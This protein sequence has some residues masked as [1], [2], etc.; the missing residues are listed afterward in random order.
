M[1]L[2]RLWPIFLVATSHTV[3]AA[4]MTPLI[5]L[6]AVSRGASPTMV[7]IVAASA[8]VLPL[9]LA[10]WTGAGADVIGPRRMAVAG[11]LVFVGSTALIAGA[12]TLGMLVV[13]TAIAGLANNALFLASQT[14][15][16]RVSRPQ[17]R[18]RNFGFFTFWVSGGQLA[19][20]LAGGFLADALSIRTALFLCAAFA[21]IP[22]S[23]A[24]WLPGTRNPALATEAAPRGLRARDA[25]RAAWILSRRRDLRFV[26]LIAFVI[27]FSWS[28]KSSFYPLYLQS[29]GLSKS[30]IGLIF[31]FLGAGSM[32]VRPLVG[33]AA[34]RFG[35]KRVLLG[36][37]L[38]A[39]AAIAT[40]PL[41]NRFWPLA[42][43]AAVTG[44]AW[45]F[46]QPLTMSLAA[47]S[48]GPH[49]RGLALSLRMT[50]NRLAEVA[51]PILFGTLV[52]WA[53]LGSAFFLS[54]VALA[55]GVW[56]IARGAFDVSGAEV[57]VPRTGTGAPAPP[58]RSD[59]APP[60]RPSPA[61]PHR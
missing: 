41:L 24:L 60:A 48:V 53:G 31:S 58:Y 40:I 34:V 39:T 43:A 47:G 30:A 18:D 36:A 4:A 28:I 15:V 3:V 19:G 57:A 11:G 52:A 16:A 20:P 61:R 7:G 23:L 12:P 2:R 17:N 9:M 27:I 45:G 44:M 42:L 50:S 13:G 29:V 35:R 37:V 51:S 25:Y 33:V 26:L 10:I 49:E 21:L 1:R 38:M 6:Y 46:T 55:V 8:A 5:P 59:V 14:S 32:V 22:C 54:A 56:I